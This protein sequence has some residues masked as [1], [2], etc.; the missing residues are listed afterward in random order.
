MEMKRQILG[1]FTWYDA[2]EI[3]RY[4]AHENVLMNMS[5]LYWRSGGD[6][7]EFYLL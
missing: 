5:S 6:G 1:K 2:E 7:D 4:Q 3:E